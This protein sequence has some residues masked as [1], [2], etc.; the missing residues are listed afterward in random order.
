[1]ILEKYNDIW[2]ILWYRE[3][4][5]TR[6]LDGVWRH[7]RNNVPL[8]EYNSLESGGITLQTLISLVA[9]LFLFD[10]LRGKWWETYRKVLGIQQLVDRVPR[11][12]KTYD[13][14][15][16]NCL[17]D[18]GE[19]ALHNPCKPCRLLI[20][21]W[22]FAR[23]V[24]ETYQK[25]WWLQLMLGDVSLSAKTYVPLGEMCFCE[26][27]EITSQTP[28]TPCRFL[29]I[30]DALREKWCKTYQRPFR[31]QPLLDRVSRHAKT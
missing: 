17:F 20:H 24:L 18:R 8:G 10:A 30:S 31:I 5:A 21:L 25:A 11:R 3:I 7:A 23:K 12:A 1:M 29:I 9:S 22:C 13:S 27:C 4:Y 16:E 2:C 6:T 28:C 26:H 19:I 15:R 14:L